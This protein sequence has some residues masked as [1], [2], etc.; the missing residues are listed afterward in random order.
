MT[1]PVTIYNA[2]LE[3]VAYLPNAYEVGYELATA[4]LGRA[5]FNLPYDDPHV[6]ECSLLR[7]VEIYDGETRV[8]LFRIVRKFLRRAD[9]VPYYRF[10]C[11]HVLG[12]LVDTVLS[13]TL[14]SGPHTAVTLAAILAQQ[15]VAHWQLGT[16]SFDRMFLYA[17]EPGTSLLKCASDVPARFQSPYLWTWDT[18]SH[19]WTLNLVATPAVVTAYIDYGR[20]LQSIEKDEDCRGL[21]TRL[22]A[23]GAGTGAEQIDITGLAPGGLPYIDAATI[24]TYGVITR[25][26][27]DQRYTVAQ[28]LYDAAVAKLA[29]DSI[30]KLT[31]AVGAADLHRI[32]EE[33]TDR[34]DLGDL[35]EVNDDEIGI[36]IQVRVEAITKGDVGGAPGDV[37]LTLANGIPEF[38]YTDVVHT[39]DLS[40]IN[41]WDMPGGMFGPLPASPSVAGLYASTNYMGISDGSIWRAYFDVAGRF[42]LVGDAAHYLTFDISGTPPLIIHA[43]G[44]WLGD[45]S[46][47]NLTAGNLTAAMNLTTGGL[48]KS[49][50]YAAGSAGWQIKADGTAE[51][52]SVTARGA[53]TALTG[54]IGG[55]TIASGLLSAGSGA[56]AVG[57]APGT[58]PFYAGS[59]TPASAPFRVT[60]AG[61]LYATGATIR[62]T[63]NASDLVA[64][65]LNFNS[66]TRTALAIIEAE[67]HPGAVTPGVMN[68]NTYLNF[69]G[70]NQYNVSGIRNGTGTSS[71]WIDL[72]NNAW[73]GYSTSS[74]LA[75]GQ[76]VA[77]RGARDATLD[78]QGGDVYVRASNRVVFACGGTASLMYWSDWHSGAPSSRGNIVVAMDGVT[79][80]IRLET[81]A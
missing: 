28:N 58:Y 75:L 10:E 12:T 33:S 1:V 13:A 37:Q 64:G 42:K 50:N 67:I 14:E 20:N 80:F 44:E 43:D 49:N 17:W 35:I 70:N 81:T 55:W 18:T 34:F 77:L 68:I 74:Y 53:I 2:A 27:T 66:I 4:T 7:Y 8:D 46:I 39:N 73:Y 40:A 48:V 65:N 71:K 76:D 32:T 15:A 52:E 25:V 16:C 23:R 3:K 63:L 26:W 45:V 36:A 72:L 61:V 11:E 59:G 56:S 21:Y 38:D 51:F 79:R 22:I 30:P 6:S 78:A 57:M 29:A 60:A 5:W 54:S 62:G 24:G 19:P 41:F 9:G 69:N 31:Y 47:S